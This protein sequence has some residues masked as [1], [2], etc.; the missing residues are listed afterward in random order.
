MWQLIRKS[1]T[2]LGTDIPKRKIHPATG[3]ITGKIQLR[4]KEICEPAVA[5]YKR[6]HLPV[7]QVLSAAAE[8]R[9]RALRLNFART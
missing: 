6:S 5:V 3:G 1:K 8:L 9:I 4:L 7:A 2:S